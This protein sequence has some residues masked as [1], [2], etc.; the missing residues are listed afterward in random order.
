MFITDIYLQDVVK[1]GKNRIAVDFEV[2]YFAGE[3]DEKYV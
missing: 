3:K 1:S 2:C